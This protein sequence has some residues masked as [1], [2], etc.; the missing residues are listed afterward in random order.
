MSAPAAPEDRIDLR[1][2]MIV[3]SVMLAVLLEIIDTSIVN[4]AL[5]AMMG[6][7]GATL[8]EID[9]VIT[10]YIISNV[11]VIPLTGWL[12]ATF[13]RKRYFVTSI[14]LF[15]FASL[16]CGLAQS[17]DALVFWRVVQGLGGGALLS[18]S[19]AIMIETFPARQQGVG[20]AIFGVGAMIGP[21]LGPTLGGWLTDNYSWHWIFLINVPLGLF[22]A[23]LCA[24]TLQ[25]PLVE[26]KRADRVDW[27]GI[28]LLVIGIGALQTLLERGHKDDWFES[29]SIVWL[30][31]AACI[32]IVAFIVRELTTDHPVVDLRVLRHKALAAG[33]G[34]GIL[35]GIGLYGSIFLLPVFTQQLLGWPAWDSGLAV[36]PS[37]VMTAVMMMLAGRLVYSV[38]PR[39]MLG[40]GMVVMIVALWQMS[41]WTLHATMDHLFW[42]QMLRGLAMGLMFVPVS[43]ATLRSLPPADLAQGAGIYNLFRQL[44]GSF[45]V[46][47]LTTVLD[48]RAE[49]HRFQFA[50]HAGRLDPIAAQQLSEAT[51]GMMARGLDP[52]A[53]ERA[54]A[55][56]LDGQVNAAASLHAFQDAYVYI[57]LLF[58]IG[59]PLVMFISRMVPGM[60]APPAPAKNDAPGEAAA[61][62][63]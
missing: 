5:P 18:T 14:L 3:F 49:V 60:E 43:I 22:A 12:A 35:M 2:L 39:A 58:V 45:G 21:S 34:L 13:G 63:A 26:P 23:F 32:G 31:A 33:C 9:W 51:A 55:A 25:K 61:A 29:R 44:G 24:S 41:H 42:P 16:M 62:H 37:S 1:R 50:E 56:M 52:H 17:A 19:Q 6:N 7:L 15:T 28:A 36:L 8:D 40:T 10:G 4:T 47:L 27:T 53:A 11:V 30:A 59:L 46:A 20:Q 38:G 57:A 54:A 48:R